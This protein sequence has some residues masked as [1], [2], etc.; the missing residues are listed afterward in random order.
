LFTKK[1]WLLFSLGLFGFVIFGFFKFNLKK[2]AQVNHP[3]TKRSSYF[4]PIKIIGFSSA[5]IPCINIEI[6]GMTIETKIDLGSAYDL[7]LPSEILQ[8]INEKQFLGYKSF[9]GIRGKEYLS[10]YFDL[11]KV[12]IGGLTFFHPKASGNDLAFDNDVK[13]QISA[14]HVVD[15]KYEKTMNILKKSQIQLGRIG[16]VLF[17]NANFLLDCKNSTIAFCDSINTL[18]Q[19]G[20]FLEEFVE[21]PLLILGGKLIGF[22][23]MSENGP[24]RCL[25]DTGCTCNMFNADEGNLEEMINDPK[26]VV[27]T[28]FFKIGEKDFGETYFIR[29]PIPFPDRVDAI[30]GMEFIYSKRIFIDFPNRKIYFSL[31]DDNL[32]SSRLFRGRPVVAE[33]G[34]VAIPAN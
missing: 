13:L 33:M 6:E 28:S 2:P 16:W 9:F 30:V 1:K 11:P 10:N 12:K 15:W 4:E 14:K 24:L 29:V 19:R 22:E 23:A 20:Y 25:L 5:R 3:A 26:N 17:Y 27:K 18:K 32:F 31:Q 34:R 8:K 21:T 7:D